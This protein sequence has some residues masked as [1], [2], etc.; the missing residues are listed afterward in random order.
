M[1]HNHNTE[2]LRNLAAF[3]HQNF[4]NESDCQWEQENWLALEI[5]HHR[6]EFYDKAEKI[7]N[8]FDQDIY[9]ANKVVQFLLISPIAENFFENLLVG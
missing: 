3:I 7:Y 5:N 2:N 1:D 9:I 8:Y 6:A 4:C